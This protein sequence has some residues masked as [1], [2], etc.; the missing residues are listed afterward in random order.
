MRRILLSS[1]VIASMGFVASL[2][3]AAQQ[4]DN[5]PIAQPQVDFVLSESP[6]DHVIGSNTAPVSMIVYASVTCPHCADWF[7]GDWPTLKSEHIDTG[8]LRVIFREF[9][10]APGQVSMAGFLL[11]NCAPSEDY[12]SMIEY[13]MEKQEELFE[14]L[15]AG[16]AGEHFD[17]LEKKAGLDT[18]DEVGTC[19]ANE[20]HFARIDRSMQRAQATGLI[21]VP[22]FVLNGALYKGDTSAAGLSDQVNSLIDSGVSSAP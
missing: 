9:P 7:N 2:D 22:G 15:K 1:L 13:Q 8:N 16:T 19:F 6:D 11:A 4:V 3:S 10:T 17:A 5:S 20:E 12:F 21:G 14:K 18:K